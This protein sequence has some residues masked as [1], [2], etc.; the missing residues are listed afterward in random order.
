MRALDAA[1]LLQIWERCLQAGLTDRVL[2]LLGAACPDVSRGELTG[3]PIGRRDALLLDLRVLLFGPDLTAMVDCPVCREPLESTFPAE[4][5]RIRPD[6]P[7]PGLQQVEAGGLDV[8][9]R[10]P[11]SSDLLSLAGSDTATARNQLLERCVLEASGK[12]GHH[13]GCGALPGDVAAAVSG[14]MSAADPQADIE[15]ALTCPSCGHE[16]AAPFD[17]A[18][19]LWAEIDACVL[20]LLRDVHVLARA[21]GWREPDVLALSPLRRS[22]YLELSQQ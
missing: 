14:C 15:L 19:F 20:R 6:S 8:V 21:Y 4:Y 18:S 1:E 16:W 17:I 3:I 2:V 13:A 7:D 9:F 11:D 5:L 12:D 22:V 10:V